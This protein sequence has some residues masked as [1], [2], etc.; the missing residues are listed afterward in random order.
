MD[1]SKYRPLIIF[2]LSLTKINTMKKTLLFIALVSG[3]MVNA[4]L[5]L[6]NEPA[7]G[8]NS[9]MFLCD[10]F[11][12]NY[13][14]TTG[15]GVTW[16]YS[17]I[18]G[19]PGETRL[20]EVVDAT[21]TPDAS[22]FPASTKA[23]KVGTSLVT[24]FNSS[25]ASRISQGFKFTEP[26]IGDVLATFETD[27]QIM[28]TYPFDFGSTVSD[29]Y[30]GT[31][32][33]VFNSIPV[34]EALTGVSTATVDGAGTLIFPGG[35]SVLN[36]IRVYSLDTTLTTVPIVGAVEVIREQYEY[37][38]LTSQNLPIFIHSTV[39]M[40]QPSAAPLAVTP[41]VLSNYEGNY[42]TINENSFDFVV[43]PNP[44]N[45]YIIVKG[46]F[47]SDTKSI[48]T[49]QSGRV[50]LTPSIISG[51]SIDLSSLESGVYMI[52]IENN[53]STSTK[54]IVKK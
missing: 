48:I 34:N 23:I 35:I 43:Y 29:N 28:M 39:T 18:M 25:A 44:A 37:Y 11:V 36:V 24:Y 7:I 14:G 31:I 40:Q 47:S 50:V 52:V 22:S 9:T 21:T 16:D 51:Q 3:S 8:E 26:S 49:D 53:G 30:A 38:D 20:V 27:D 1:D 45:D 17:T 10:S 41:M 2:L 5:N 4:Q 12:T 32:D 54:T 13:A 15:S 6:S 46:D 19:Y 42:L 33:F